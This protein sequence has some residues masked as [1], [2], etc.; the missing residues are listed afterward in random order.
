MESDVVGWECHPGREAEGRWSSAGK[1]V[2]SLEAQQGHGEAAG[3]RDVRGEEITQIGA[4][5]TV[6]RVRRTCWASL[7]GS[8][9][10]APIWGLCTCLY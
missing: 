1:R 8:H 6:R 7:C 3:W 2:H 4:T 9:V 10:A 5:I